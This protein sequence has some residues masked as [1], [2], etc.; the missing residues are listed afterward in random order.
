[1]AF[2]RTEKMRYNGGEEILWTYPN[3]K[4]EII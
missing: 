1:M 2:Y 3:P 4:G